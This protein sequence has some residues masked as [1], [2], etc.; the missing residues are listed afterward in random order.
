MFN[1]NSSTILE[2][3]LSKPKGTR[4]KSSGFLENEAWIF[5]FISFKNTCNGYFS[6]ERMDLATM[7]L[8]LWASTG[9]I[10]SC[11]GG[12]AFALPSLFMFMFSL[13]FSFHY[14]TF[15]FIVVGLVLFCFNFVSLL[16]TSLSSFIF[17]YSNTSNRTQWLS[18]AVHLTNLGVQLFRRR[19]IVHCL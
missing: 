19:F 9:A 5:Y 7:V 17:I 13:Y 14:P 11:Q 3:T 2:R 1:H 6:R 8:T 4:H 15:T 10:D 16:V 18:L 12:H